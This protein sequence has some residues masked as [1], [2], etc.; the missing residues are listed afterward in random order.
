MRL[1][2]IGRQDRL[3]YTDSERLEVIFS[4]NDVFFD[5]ILSDKPLPGYDITDTVEQRYVKRF[6]ACSEW[7]GGVGEEP[8]EFQDLEEELEREIEA[9]LRI[10]LQPEILRSALTPKDDEAKPRTLRE[11][12]NPKVFGY[13]LATLAGEAVLVKHDEVPSVV[14]HP[15]I[16]DTAISNAKVPVI[17]PDSIQVIEKLAYYWVVKVLKDGQAMVC[18]LTSRS[19][20][21]SLARE[22]DALQMILDSGIAPAIRCP[23]MR[24]VIKGQDGGL[25]G[26][27][28]DYVKPSIS[29]LENGLRHEKTISRSMRERWATQIEETLQQLHDI[30]VVW[31]DA[32]SANILIDD[33]HNAW[34]L[35]FGGGN[36]VGWVPEELV[37]TKE[38]DLH[39]LKIILEVIMKD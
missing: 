10:L 38:G 17:S 27:L 4:C 18:K 28:L 21:D 6:T 1:I 30:N 39:A 35:D 23:I 2:E 36:T 13:Q 24:G 15:P 34:I 8:L 11:H 5:V 3:H 32:K 20:H 14:F 29:N 9:T 31:G 19:G 16:P 26:I 37:G 12:M 33:N 7:D 22:Y 25:V